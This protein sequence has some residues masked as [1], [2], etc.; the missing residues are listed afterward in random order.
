M[1]MI[2]P[3][4]SIAGGLEKAAERAHALGAN[5]FGMFSKNQR[6]WRAKPIETEQAERFKETLHSLGFLPEAVLV[7]NSYL[8]NLANPDDEKQARSLNSFIDEIKRIELLGLSLLNFHPGSHLGELSTEAATERIARALDIAI[9][10]TEYASLVIENTAGSGSNLG[11]SVEELAMILDAAR[12]PE[13]IGFCLDTCHAHVAGYDLSTLEGFEALI[14]TFDRLIGLEKLLGMHLNDAKSE[15]GS[16]LDR[17]AS[18]G[19]GT[20]GWELFD[21]IA[22]DDRF[23]AIPLILETVDES[24]WA[25]EVARL[26]GH[27]G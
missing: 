24:L 26:R 22:T 16:R 19:A 3:H 27:H 12:H 25:D 2:G 18:L 13:R 6:Q 11:S 9:E 15:A 4:T 10:E 21:S 23:A 7:H 5:A 14:E 17:H 8:I 1:H 20:I